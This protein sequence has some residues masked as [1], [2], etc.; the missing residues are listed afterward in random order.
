M[1]PLSRAPITG[2]GLLELLNESEGAVASHLWY[3][4]TEV[5]EL[6]RQL[7]DREERIAALEIELAFVKSQRDDNENAWLCEKAKRG[8]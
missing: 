3:R 2:L 7:S 4:D 8:A 5:I 1:S 6:L